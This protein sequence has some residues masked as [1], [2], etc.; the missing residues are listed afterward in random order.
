MTLKIQHQ[1]VQKM[2]LI[3]WLSKLHKLLLDGLQ[4]L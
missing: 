3:K 2:S 4:Q 1:I